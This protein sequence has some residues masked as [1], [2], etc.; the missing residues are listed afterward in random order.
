M[1]DPIKTDRLLLRPLRLEDA[2]DYHALETDTRVKQYL[3]G[4]SKLTVGQYQSNITAGTAGLALNL[5]ITRA[6][7]GAFLGRC[8]F[9]KYIEFFEPI[10]WEI[11]ILLHIDQ[12]RRGYGTE[13][14]RALITRGFAV[15]GCDKI[16][17]VTDATNAGSLSLCSRLGMTFE[18]NTMRYG[19]P[20]R[21]Y[22]VA[23]NA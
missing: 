21:I 7:T 6:D 22:S 4:P 17:G 14:G 15:L 1:L 2:S 5:A 9:T 18:R 23:K 13:V 11:N 19:R 8:G 3:D 20:A 12:W 10:G 16:F